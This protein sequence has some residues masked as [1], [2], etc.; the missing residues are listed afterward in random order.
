MGSGAPPAGPRE[1]VLGLDAGGKGW[2]RRRGGGD[3]SDDEIRLVGKEIVFTHAGLLLRPLTIPAGLLTVATVDPGRSSRKDAGD[4]GRFPILHRL[5]SRAVVPVEEGLEGW[6][7]TSKSGS[8]LLSLGDAVPNLALVFFKP[9][10]EAVVAETFRPAALAALAER[11]PL[12]VPAV[13]GLLARV[14][15]TQLAERALRELGLDQP[16]TDREVAPPQRRHLPTD[17]A[18]NPSVRIGGDLGR[19][20]TSVP[21]PGG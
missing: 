8:A 17:R 18:A 19:E 1:I 12:G 6:L 10:D 2:R 5:G 15:D 13:V 3:S 4:F 11:S 7:W 16:L 9:L 14:A 20:S 21:P